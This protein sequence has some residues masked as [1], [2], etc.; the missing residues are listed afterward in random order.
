VH[1]LREGWVATEGTRDQRISDDCGSLDL[2][3]KEWQV[4][5]VGQLSPGM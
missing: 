1:D 4:S 5:R 2:D 3:A